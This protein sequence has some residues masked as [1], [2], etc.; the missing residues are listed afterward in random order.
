MLNETLCDSDKQKQAH[1]TNIDRKVKQLFSF[2]R[3]SVDIYI[4][5]E[6]LREEDETNNTKQFLKT[7]KQV[8]EEEDNFFFE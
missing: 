2:R 6:A 3:L 1:M 4:K 5:L 8:Q 7:L